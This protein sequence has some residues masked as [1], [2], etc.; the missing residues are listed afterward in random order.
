[1][2]IDLGITYLKRGLG[3]FAD[4]AFEAVSKG[5]KWACLAN[6]W[7]LRMDDNASVSHI[8]RALYR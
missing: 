7:T 6:C 3:Q 8:C 2:Q 5:S 4:Q 1:V